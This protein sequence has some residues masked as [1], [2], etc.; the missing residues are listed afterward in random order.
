MKG[1]S[2]SRTLTEL[3][4]RLNPS[5]DT[6]ITCR[7]E[8][9]VLNGYVWS[10]RWPGIHFT[11]GVQSRVNRLRRNAPQGLDLIVGG[12]PT[13][14]KARS[15]DAQGTTFIPSAQLALPFCEMPLPKMSINR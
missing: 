5:G 11:S 6:S 9:V 1:S 4:K 10:A 2:T 7:M 15:A 14:S 8:D 12:T 3:I 13:I